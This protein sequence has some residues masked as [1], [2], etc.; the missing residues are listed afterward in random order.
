MSLLDTLPEELL[1]TILANVI[2]P[3]S[4]HLKK[5]LR[6]V[7][8]R[9]HRI[10]TPL[11]FYTIHLRSQAQLDGLLVLALRHN[12]NLAS[13]IRKIIIEGVWTE[14][15]ALFKLCRQFGSLKI[16]DMTID[17]PPPSDELVKYW[18]SHLGMGPANNV[19]VNITGTSSDGEDFCKHLHELTSVTHLT[20]RKSSHV[21]LT[22]TK[23]R[24]VL[25]QLARAI[26]A[27]KD[28]VCLYFLFISQSKTWCAF[29]NMLT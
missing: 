21:H 18:L 28:L 15:E 5:P 2:N 19:R 9:F 1:E 4:P 10:S 16:L 12:T 22:Q 24:L 26:K 20:I 6:L 3:I 17:P 14:A 13:H 7:S 8:R 11:Y 27:W 25:S 29:R 23:P